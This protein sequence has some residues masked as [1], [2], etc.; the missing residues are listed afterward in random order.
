MSAP[1]A[2]REYRPPRAL[3]PLVACLWEN[4]AVRD[5]PQSVVPDGCVDL[6]WLGG[7]GLQVA[8]PD[9]AA[10]LA[11][12]AG[13][14]AFGI[15][16][17]PGAAGAVLGLPAAEVRDRQPLLA[18]LWGADGARLA[19]ALGAVTG[20]DRLAL[21]TEA[22]LRRR[23]EPDRLVVA[24]AHR[25][26]VRGARVG[27]VA[28]DL[29]VS[30]RHLHRRTLAAVGYGPK[31]L[32]RV[33]RLRALVAAPAVPLAERAVAAGYASQAHMT[34]EV[35]RLTGTTPVRFLEDAR[36]TAA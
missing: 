27:D 10:R 13:E 34:D 18:D 17:R 5:R 31:L 29:G 20:H 23:A 1:D 3:A 28:R 12:P 33:L 8:G 30:E 36:P 16:L 15:R 14:P 24:A 4:A 22:V 11:P 7:L 2:Y 32:A 35:R 6:I 21:L 9:T 19:D 25:L 26:A